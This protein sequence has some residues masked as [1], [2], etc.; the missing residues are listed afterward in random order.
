MSK[1]KL[2][3]MTIKVKARERP[4]TLRDWEV[5]AAL[6]GRKTM[7]RR[8]VFK[9]GHPGDHMPWRAGGMHWQDGDDRLR[10]PYEAGMKLWVRENWSD[11]MSEGGPVICYRA[12]LDRRYLH[13]DAWPIDY[14]R[15]PTRPFAN[16]ASDLEA[17]IEG[18]WRSSR[19]MPRWASRITLEVA[20]VRVE[21]LNAITEADAVAEGSWAWTASLD[22]RAYDIAEKAWCHWSKRLDPDATVAGARGAFA[23]HW[24][25][26]IGKRP[27]C[28]WASKPWV[29]VV[30]FR[31][32]A[33]CAASNDKRTNP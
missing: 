31:M 33:P 4:L 2:T 10:C 23:A 21:R 13:F 11:A 16:W 26:T 1:G 15:Y 29:W 5:R 28:D 12:N 24:A 27:G 9:D 3:A 8:A 25:A 32:V 19:T 6:A 20:D 30:A 22:G 17:G 18:W 7:F 14:E